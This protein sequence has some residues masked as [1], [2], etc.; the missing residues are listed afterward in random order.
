MKKQFLIVSLVVVMLVSMLPVVALA[1]APAE[2]QVDVRNQTGDVA[3]VSLTDANGNPIYL[4]F[5]AGNSTISLTEGYYTAY[6]STVCGSY[7]GQ[8]HVDGKKVIYIECKAGD[9]APL[10]QYDRCH[11]VNSAYGFKLRGIGFIADQNKFI[12]IEYGYDK[13]GWDGDLQNYLRWIP[14]PV[15]C[16]YGL[17]AEDFLKVF[18]N[19]PNR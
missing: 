2:I 16:R 15:S 14:I 1:A 6:V 7:A 13:N 8:W 5:D 4:S 3:Q 18:P 12:D 19:R 17:E 9:T 11:Y 10:V